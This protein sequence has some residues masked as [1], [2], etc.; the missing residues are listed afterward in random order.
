MNGSKTSNKRPRL[1]IDTDP[2]AQPC[3]ALQHDQQGSRIK[4]ALIVFFVRNHD[5]LEMIDIEARVTPL[6]SLDSFRFLFRRLP[7]PHFFHEIIDLFNNLFPKYLRDIHGR[8]VVGGEQRE[9]LELLLI[10]A[11]RVLDRVS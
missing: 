2:L 3:Q 6:K 9:R 1:R 10:I 7:N 4:K 5:L 8:E 11:A